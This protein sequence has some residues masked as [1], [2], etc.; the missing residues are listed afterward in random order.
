MC[1][2]WLESDFRWQSHGNPHF[3]HR[4]ILTV[5]IRKLLK[6]VKTTLVWTVRIDVWGRS[7][8]SLSFRNTSGAK[9][10]LHQQD[11]QKGWAKLGTVWAGCEVGKPSNPLNSRPRQTSPNVCLSWVSWLTST[12]TDR[13]SST[14]SVNYHYERPAFIHLIGHTSSNKK[15]FSFSVLQ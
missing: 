1:A 5:Q 8:V 12:P 11:A 3:V 6:M 9:Y 10:M 15:T 7:V 2:I 14:T 4:S 13:T